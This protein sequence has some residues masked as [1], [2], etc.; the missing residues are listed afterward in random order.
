MLRAHKFFC[1]F[2][3]SVNNFAFKVSGVAKITA[4]VTP[5]LV[6]ITSF[7]TRLKHG[8]EDWF[9]KIP[10]IAIGKFWYCG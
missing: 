3:P 10:M 5:Q 8:K 7:S 1:T 6:G 2:A 9:G 4:T